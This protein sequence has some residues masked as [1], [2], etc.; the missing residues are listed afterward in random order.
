[1]ISAFTFQEPKLKK[2]TQTNRRKNREEKRK[3]EERRKKNVLK[4]KF[5][6]RLVEEVD[7]SDAFSGTW[8]AG[9]AGVAAVELFDES[10]CR[11]IC[12]G[13][14]GVFGVG[15]DLYG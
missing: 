10:A 15:V 6:K 8:C 11:Y 9:F 12:E 1:V 5:V 7:N 2:K 13:L 3:K 4:S 14:P